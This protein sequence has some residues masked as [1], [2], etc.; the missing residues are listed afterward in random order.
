MWPGWAA[1]AHTYYTLN[2]ERKERRKIRTLALFKLLIKLL[3]PTFGNPTTPTV[4]LC[5]ALG[6]YAFNN[7]SK[8]GAVLEE[9]F[10]RW[11]WDA[12]RKGRVGVECRR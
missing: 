9:R 11:F 7:F 8:L 4:T 1:T 5:A 12:L 2:K 10:V 6:L 3:F